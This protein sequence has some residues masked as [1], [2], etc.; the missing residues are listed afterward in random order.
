VQFHVMAT[1]V[2]AL[3]AEEEA[4][5][6]AITPVTHTFFHIG[7][8]AISDTV[9]SAWISMAVLVIFSLLVTRNMKMVPS[10]LQNAGEMI[11]E[12]WLGILEST[13]GKPGRRFLPIVATAFLFI[14]FSNLLGTTPFYGNVVGFRSAMSDLNLTA[15]MAV[16]VFFIAQ[17]LSI[18]SN[19]VGGYLKHL[20]IP[21]PLEILTELS[22]PLSLSLRLFGNIFAGGVLVHTMLGLAPFITFAFL[23][24]EIFVGVIQSLIFS[25]L[26]LVFLSIAIAHEQG[27]HGE[28]EAEAA[29]HHH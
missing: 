10:G 22:R 13:A 5:G 9:F 26:T 25:M 18:Q 28:A 16:A 7:P 3:A 20:V 4:H 27:E 21:N 11:I 24:L 15:A 19:G 12:A 14:L 17:A 8:L 2:A 6:G 23:G 1:E 29:S